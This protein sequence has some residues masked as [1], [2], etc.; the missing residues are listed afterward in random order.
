MTTKDRIIYEALSLFSMRGYEA[1]TIRQIATAVGIKESSV[2]N[3]FENK[4][5]ILDTIVRETINRYEKVLQESNVP[6]IE[7]PDVSG[8]FDSICDEDFYQMCTGVFLFYLKDEYISKLRRLL[9]I[10]QYSNPELGKTFKN[11]FI[12]NIL[13][14]QAKVLQK[15]ID[16]GRFIPGDAYTMAL[17]F[18]AP[19][20]LLL[21]K[22]DN[23]HENE[24][25]AIAELRSHVS[26]YNALY[27]AD[28][29]IMV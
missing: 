3:H 23:N 4:Q 15:F 21:Y 20:F 25:Q 27:K 12:N 6:G 18:Y 16:S 29:K 11:I 10:E 22:Y 2:Y 7:D 28:H 26:Q 9:T 17:H 19:V 5:D 8:S 13:E 1:V 14:N 24:E